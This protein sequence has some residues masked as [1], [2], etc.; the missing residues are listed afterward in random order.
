MNVSSSA[1]REEL[2]SD[3]YRVVIRSAF[4]R[5]FDNLSNLDPKVRQIALFPRRAV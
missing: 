2:D 3:G 5:S 1:N 4:E